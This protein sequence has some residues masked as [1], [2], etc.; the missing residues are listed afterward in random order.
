ML[1]L[2]ANT[3]TTL[4]DN[5]HNGGT[6]L[7]ILPEHIPPRMTTC[8]ILGVAPPVLDGMGGRGRLGVMKPALLWGGPTVCTAFCTPPAPV[9]ASHLYT[10]S[11]GFLGM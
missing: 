10:P 7:L 5:R 6:V 9:Q 1:H 8:I 4:C 3:Y 11:A 2:T